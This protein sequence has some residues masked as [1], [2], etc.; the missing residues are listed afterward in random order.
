MKPP[1]PSQDTLRVLLVAPTGADARRSQA[2]LAEAGI[3]CIVCADV[4]ALCATLQ[5]GVGTIVLT[6]ESLAGDNLQRLKTALNQQPPWSDLPIIVLTQGGA[7]SRVAIYALDMLGNVMVLDRPVRVATLVSVVRT[8]L[9]ARARQYQLREHLIERAQA[10]EERIQL[11]RTEQQAR[12]AAEAAVQLR[13]AFLSIAAHELKTPLTSLLGNIQLIE[14]RIAQHGELSE[15]DR[16]AIHVASQQGHRL[17]QMIDALLDVSRLEHGQLSITREPVDLGRLVEQ[18]IREVQLGV[19]QHTIECSTPAEPV[20]T[21]GDDLR[22]E[23]VLQNLLQNAIKYSPNGGAIVVTVERQASHAVVHVR[24]HGVG[25][26]AAAI[27][28]LFERFYRVPDVAEQHIQ[29]AGIGLYVVKEIVALHGGTVGATSQKDGGS[30]FTIQLPL[31]ER[32]GV[33][34]TAERREVSR[35][36]ASDPTRAPRRGSGRPS[37]LVVDDDSAIRALLSEVLR[38]EGY[39]V[40]SVANGQ[41]ALHELGHRDD[42]PQLILLDLMM[43]IMNGW[44]FLSH[45]QQDATLA[46]IPV[47]V[48][49]AG[50]T[51]QQQPLP[52]S[53]ATFLSKPL[54]IELLLGI[55]D[56]HCHA[57]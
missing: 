46:T 4:A 10:A 38:D 55:V 56:R 16:Q 20:L 53:S 35:G 57:R 54:D 27:P 37:V 48:I 21:L 2:L 11:Y 34:A 39:H 47:V 29:G 44:T 42:L 52:H 33:P 36:P 30:T 7:D 8:A 14:R 9:R 25:I 23:Q 19:T 12:A 15:R 6:E 51:L 28:H 45:Q 26:P 43:P 18:V 24:D 13:D 32:T 1:E 17:K 49:S 41:E 31:L 50:S 3:A 40:V 5:D 22:L